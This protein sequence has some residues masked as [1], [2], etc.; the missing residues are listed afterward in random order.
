M[1]KLMI[2]LTLHFGLLPLLLIYVAFSSQTDSVG[3]KK[4]LF[5]GDV[6]LTLLSVF[7]CPKHLELWKQLPACQ[8]TTKWKWLCTDAQVHFFLMCLARL[9]LEGNILAT[10]VGI[11]V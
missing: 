7:S 1:K 5:Q 11:Y 6:R 8:A 2:V 9:M 10:G 4:S 3:E